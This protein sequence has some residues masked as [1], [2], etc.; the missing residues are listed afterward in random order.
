[1][2]TNYFLGLSEEGFHRIAYSEWGFPSS[3]SPSILCVHGLTRNRRDFDDLA[4]Y[5]SQQELHLVC[6]DMVGRGDSDWLKDPIHYTFEQYLADCNVLINRMPSVKIDWI[7]TSMGGIIGMILASLPHSPIQRLILNDTGPQIEL[8]GLTRLM[9][10]ASLHPTFSTLEEAVQYHKTTLPEIGD[11]TESQWMRMTENSVQETKPGLFTLKFDPNSRTTSIKS[12]IAWKSILHPY[13]ALEGVLFDIDL[14]HIWKMVR[15][16]VL[17]IHGKKSDI[18]SDSTIQKMR[19]SPTP[20]TVIEVA[21]V[22]HAPSLL[23]PI[24][25]ELIYDWLTHANT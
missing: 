15:C 4:S 25:H 11:L 8:S 16:P 14:W 18:L 12:K 24:H 13:K 10:N 2:K 23:D 19:H 1:M 17:V 5:L 22:G 7:G 9:M 20:V 6:P 3:H 21:E